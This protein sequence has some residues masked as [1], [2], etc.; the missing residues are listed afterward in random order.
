[1]ES[2]ADRLIEQYRLDHHV[3]QNTFADTYAAFD[4][5]T[6]R[7]VL[8]GILLATYAEDELFR[9][10]YLRRTRA[11][12]QIHHPNIAIIYQTG[13]TLEDR[14]YAVHEQVDGYPLSDRL[15]R[16]AKQQSPAHA[17]YALTLIQQIATGLSLAERLGYYHYELTPK[18]IM[19][20]NVT[21]KSD[22]SVVIVNL[23]IPPRHEQQDESSKANY[24]KR[25]LSPEQLN[26][27]EID[28]RSLV[29]SLGII[30]FELLTGKHPDQVQAGRLHSF[31]TLIMTGR[32]L[33]RLRP[34]L[35]PE[36]C[37]LVEK[38]VRKGPRGRYG[39]VSEF[40]DALKI[41]LV[42]EDL[43][44]HTSNVKDP[45]RPWPIFL[46]PLLL[47]LICL[48]LAVSFLWIFPRSPATASQFAGINNANA[49]VTPGS[50]QVSPTA[51]N[52]QKAATPT[53]P[54]QRKQ[55]AA[56]RI[57]DASSTSPTIEPTATPT[58]GPTSTQTSTPTITG[59]PPEP[60]V[61]KTNP[62]VPSP[63][64][65]PRSEYRI[66]V[67]SASLRFG[68]GIR[69]GVDSYLLEEDK[70]VILGKN[71]GSDI[72]YVVETADGR[73]G[74]ISATVGEPAV[75]IALNS[76]PVAA[77]IPVPPPTF[78]PTPTA[79]PTATATLAPSGGSSV[80]GG[81]KDDEDK[82][83]PTPTPPI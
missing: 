36:T 27:R 26:G 28:G 12:S 43:R 66:S 46:L 64:S 51:T 63:T 49:L 67:S 38:A 53:L 62:T 11:L 57:I 52:A 15:N 16:L 60:T 83:R 79:T 31:R 1:M 29:Y 69:F 72:W 74:W 58:H 25:Y 76:I 23:D 14:P 7:K 35:T 77:T 44:I 50:G 19:L 41:A 65:T 61:T 54:A 32:S 40:L 45:R 80:G 2:T 18:H 59:T 34:D 82:P 4:L 37:A 81:N 48:T 55:S 10:Q 8:L 3:G 9:Q 39:S 33:H 75:E 6:N 68:P 24:R 17:I 21:L 70:V 42:A 5:E 30:L 47:L 73:I 22:D 71:N 13:V 56:G 78:T 20:R